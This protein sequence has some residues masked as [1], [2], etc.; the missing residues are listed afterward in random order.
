MCAQCIAAPCRH[1]TTALTFRTSRFTHPH[2]MPLYGVS[3]DGPHLCIVYPFM[4]GSSLAAAI[5][6]KRKVRQAEGTLLEDTSD[7]YFTGVLT[8]PCTIV[9]PAVVCL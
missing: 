8:V 5:K 2:L 1:W 4:S 6:E 9:E 7:I 3:Q